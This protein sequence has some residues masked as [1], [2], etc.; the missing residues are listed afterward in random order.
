MTQRESQRS[1]ISW[2]T[3]RVTAMVSAGLGP[4]QELHPKSQMSHRGTNISV[5]FHWFFHAFSKDLDW[6]WSSRT[7]N[8]AH[9]GC[10]CCRW[11]LYQQKQ[12]TDGKEGVKGGG[13]K[14][15]FLILVHISNAI[16]EKLPC[17]L[18]FFSS[19]SVDSH[20]QNN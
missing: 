16:L 11:Q 19:T 14:F 10:L 17:Q 18:S 15:C 6:K 7:Q 12:R 3:P 2:F 9:K 1:S 8:S 20:E 13:G 4:N 5:I